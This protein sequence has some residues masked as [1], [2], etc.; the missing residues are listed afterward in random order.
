MIHEIATELRAELRALGVPLAVVDGPEPTTTTTWAR[1]RIV[2]SFDEGGTDS[3]VLPRALKTNARHR[4]TA[5]E[6]CK[7]TIYAQSP[8]ASATPFEHRARAKRIRNHVLC[9]LDV[10]SAKRRNR[11]A[12]QSGRFTTPEDLDKSEQPKGAV[13]EISFVF[14]QAVAALT[15]K[16]EGNAEGLISAVGNETNV[17]M[18]NG[19]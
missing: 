7:I 12:P 17:A 4:Y 3:F 1:E 16:G 5:I 2:V 19:A 13:Y 10:V 6:A 18:T 15:W 14:E 9:A 8:A 11:W